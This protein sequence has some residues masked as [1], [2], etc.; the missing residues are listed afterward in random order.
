MNSGRIEMIPKDERRYWN[1]GTE[2]STTVTLS[3]APA[4]WEEYLRLHKG[5]QWIQALEQINRLIAYDPHQPEI[6]RIKAKLHGVLG[7]SACCISAIEELLQLT[8]DDLDGLRMQAMFLHC[9]DSL[10]NALNICESVLLENPGHADFWALKAD[11]LK[12]CG[13]ICDALRA[14]RRALQ[15]QPDCAAALRLQESLS[16]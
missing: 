7:H 5:G 16:G 4:V 13:R 9:N 14:C 3:V 1:I 15:V 2:V 6:W 12:S 11:I 10:E 8:P